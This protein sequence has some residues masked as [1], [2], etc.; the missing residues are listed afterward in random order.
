MAYE[1]KPADL[2]ADKTS[3]LYCSPIFLCSFLSRWAV[4]LR[5]FDA[6]FASKTEARRLSLAWKASILCPGEK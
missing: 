2:N 1:L 5:Y 4:T 3:I 6:F